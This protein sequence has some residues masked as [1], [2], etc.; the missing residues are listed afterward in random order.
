MGQSMLAVEK[1][2]GYGVGLGGVKIKPEMAK[3]EG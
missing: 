2:L 1:W 3:S